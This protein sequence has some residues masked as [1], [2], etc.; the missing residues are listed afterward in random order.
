MENNNAFR[1]VLA[2]AVIIGFFL[3]WFAYGSVVS[4]WDIF[5]SSSATESTLEKVISYS[6]LAIPLFALF[7]LIRSLSGLF[8][9]FLLRFLP[10]LITA[11]LSALF[12]IG[13]KDQ[14][15]N[16]GLKMFFSILG[17][18]YYITVIASLLLAFVGGRRR[19]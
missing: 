5:R 2:A 12:A 19:I 8:S 17:Y 4:G 3:P 6:F 15:G 7:V 13:E 9:G 1:M 18:G 14:N 11:L 16:E 10:F